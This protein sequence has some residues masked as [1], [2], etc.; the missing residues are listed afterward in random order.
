MEVNIY[1]ASGSRAQRKEKRCNCYILEAETSKGP[2]TLTGFLQVEDTMHGAA[3]RTLEKAAGRINCDTPAVLYADDDYLLATVRG[4]DG[5]KDREF[6]RK[7]GEPVAFAEHWQA[8]SSRL[9]PI[10]AAGKDHA[11]ADWMKR[12][13]AAK[14][15]DLRLERESEA[16]KVGS[17]T[18]LSKD[19]GTQEKKEA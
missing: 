3:V 5:L 1:I 13:L 10:R 16:E 6:R 7:D 14:S 8:I 4:L 9:G 2:A 11:Y 19:S 15:L 18:D 17:G 12:E